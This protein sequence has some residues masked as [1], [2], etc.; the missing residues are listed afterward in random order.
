M[1]EEIKAKIDA[2]IAE[3]E[4]EIAQHQ[5]K[6]DRLRVL[7]DALDDSELA[8]ELAAEFKT[9]ANSKSSAAKSKSSKEETKIKVKSTQLEKVID[10]FNDR[11]NEWASTSEIA[12][13]S[14]LQ[15]HSIRQMV[16][17]RYVNL[18]ERR[19]HPHESRR[20]QF[21]LKNGVQLERTQ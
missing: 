7:R 12:V 18:F 2:R 15:P 6:I 17:K 3:H 14:D 11:A 21:R 20:K 19:D 5:E 10:F 1:Y 13:G 9:Q 4:G 8:A 16:Y